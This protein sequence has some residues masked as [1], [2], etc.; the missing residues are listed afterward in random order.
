MFTQF[1]KPR[2]RWCLGPF[3][4]P[5][6]TLGVSDDAL[7]SKLEEAN[8]LAAPLNWLISLLHMKRLLHQVQLF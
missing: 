2:T 7:G 6:L 8:L 5:V 1:G 3:P 4:A